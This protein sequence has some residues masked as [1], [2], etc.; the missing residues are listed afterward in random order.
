M[1]PSGKVKRRVGRPHVCVKPEDVNEMRS[2]GASWRQIGKALRIGTATAMRLS[3]SCDSTCPNNQRTRPKTLNV[4]ESSH[5][6]E[7]TTKRE[8]P[9]VN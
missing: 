1:M 3:K 8:K 6:T 7:M 5:S 4:E 9:F 2:Q